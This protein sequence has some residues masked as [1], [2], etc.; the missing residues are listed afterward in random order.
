[1]H[2]Q[3]PT[4]AATGNPVPAPAGLANWMTFPKVPGLFDAATRNPFPAQAAGGTLS[5]SAVICPS[6]RQKTPP[7]SERSRDSD[8]SS[9]QRAHA[10]QIRTTGDGATASG[11]A[12]ASPS[13]RPTQRTQSEGETTSKKEPR[14]AK[15]ATGPDLSKILQ[16]GPTKP[17]RPAN[18]GAQGHHRYIHNVPQLESGS[19]SVSHTGNNAAVQS[20]SSESQ[21]GPVGWQRAGS[22][23]GFAAVCPSSSRNPSFSTSA[24]AA[25]SR[26]VPRTGNSGS[27]AARPSGSGSTSDS[28]F[29]RGPHIGPGARFTFTK[30]STVRTKDATDANQ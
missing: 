30:E 7:T 24:F 8:G 25:S 4:R 16:G 28:G 18:T 9:T 2:A 6:R 15:R 21:G 14:G 11:K 12:L 3:Y 27:A 10:K 13:P 5:L 1:M 23:L 22:D 17:S 26:S 19:G 29:A 20:S